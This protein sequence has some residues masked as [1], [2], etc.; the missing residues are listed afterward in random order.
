MFGG[1]ARSFCYF[2]Y[3]DIVICCFGTWWFGGAVDPC[4]V[5][6]MFGRCAWS[7]CY[8]E[9]ADIVICCFGNEIR[10]YRCGKKC[11]LILGVLTLKLFS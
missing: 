2:E 11:N 10:L 4:I 7:Y 8:F 1:C 5:I 6:W 3:A 9:Y